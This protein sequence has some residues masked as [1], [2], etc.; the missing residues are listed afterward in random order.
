M[1]HRLETF[2][3]PKLGN[4]PLKQITASDL[5]RERIEF[6]ENAQAIVNYDEFGLR[7]GWRSQQCR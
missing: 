3:F 2:M 7:S 1:L 4:T 6:S 5:H